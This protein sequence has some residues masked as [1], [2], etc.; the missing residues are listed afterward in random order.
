[1][2]NNIGNVGSAKSRGAKIGDYKA[3]CD[4]TGFRV[5][6]SECRYQWDGIF[7][8]TKNWE[9]RHPQDFIKAKKDNLTVP[10]AR[11]EQKILVPVE[12][13]DIDLFGTG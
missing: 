4:R 5:Y 10:V 12:D 3:V 6:A 8:R 13:V 9:I 2:F 1:M 11:P 7:V